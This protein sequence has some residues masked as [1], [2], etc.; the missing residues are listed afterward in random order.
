M[1]G[2]AGSPDSPGTLVIIDR[3]QSAKKDP[4]TTAYEA[5]P[6]VKPPTKSKSIL[7]ERTRST[8]K[9]YVSPSE[10]ERKEPLLQRPAELFLAR[11][12]L[13]GSVHRIFVAS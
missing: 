13:H 5:A 4:S 2:L 6:V 3:S 11:E 9:R 8:E 7:A 12:K 1:A 10:T